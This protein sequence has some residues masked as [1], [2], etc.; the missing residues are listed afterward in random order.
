MM[1]PKLPASVMI[2]SPARGDRKAKRRGHGR[3][4]IIIEMYGMKETN[5][6]KALVVLYADWRLALRCL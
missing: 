4:I 2:S 1:A 5:T 3:A 6:Q